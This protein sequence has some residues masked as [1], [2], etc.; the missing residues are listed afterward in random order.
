M[1]RGRRDGTIPGV[2]KLV[3][4]SSN[5]GKIR[6]FEQLLAPLGIEIVPQ[7]RLGIPDAE[8]PHDTFIENALAKAR[9]AA[10]RSKLAALADDSGICVR[11]LAGEPGVH[12]ARYASDGPPASGRE[13]QD[14][15][16]NDQLIQL[17]RDKEDRR[18]HYYCIVVL[19]RHGDD[20]EPLIAEG[21][22]Q[23]E[24]VAEPR[25]RNGFGYDP[26]FWVTELART[27][28]ELEPGEKNLVSHRG[29]ALRRLVARL[30]E[31]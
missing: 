19:M 24:I 21:T 26:H 6:E 12:S 9:H 1:E 17:L 18:A 13:E 29:K 16:N 3:L 23:G 14:R 7:S 5:P 27:A 31:S 10:R 22:W 11:A 25:G 4:A 20:P 30:K 2:K 15:R 8:E 28:A